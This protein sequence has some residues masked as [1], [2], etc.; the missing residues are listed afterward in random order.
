MDIGI[1]DEVV[2]PR[3]E[4]SEYVKTLEQ[5]ISR[6]EKLVKSRDDTLNELYELEKSKSDEINS[7]KE[8]IKQDGVETSKLQNIIKALNDEISSLNEKISDLEQQ[9]INNLKQQQIIEAS[10]PR[11]VENLLTDKESLYK[12]IA[13]LRLQ[14]SQLESNLQDKEEEYIALQTRFSEFEI[15]KEKEIQLLL[16]ES[17]DTKNFFSEKEQAQKDIYDSKIN[18]LDSDIN[19]LKSDCLDLLKLVALLQIKFT[20]NQEENFESIQNAINLI[21]RSLSLSDK[22]KELIKNDLNYDFN[23]SQ[24]IIS[25]SQVLIDSAI[26]LPNS[27]TNIEEIKVK[28]NDQTINLIQNWVITHFSSLL[29]NQLPLSP[30]NHTDSL[31]KERDYILNCIETEYFVVEK[32]LNKIFIDSEKSIEE[33]SPNVFQILSDILFLDINNS[34]IQSVEDGF[35]NSELTIIDRECREYLKTELLFKLVVK[36]VIKNDPEPLITNLNEI[37]SSINSELSKPQK[38]EFE[39]PEACIKIFS[40][41]KFIDS[42]LKLSFGYGWNFLHIFSYLEHIETLQLLLEHFS[43]EEQINIVNR[44]S[45]SGFIPISLS[46]LKNNLLMTELFLACGTD[47]QAQDNRRN[48]LIHFAVNSDIQ[49]VLIKRRILLN[50]KNSSGQIANVIQARPQIL[51]FDLNRFDNNESSD[52]EYKGSQPHKSNTSSINNYESDSGTSKK[53]SFCCQTF[54]SREVEN[55]VML[56]AWISGN[57]PISSCR[58]DFCV[59]STPEF[60]SRDSDVVESSVWNMLGFVGNRN[61][62]SIYKCKNGDHAAMEQNLDRLDEM[63]LTSAERKKGIWSDIVINYT[64]RG[65]EKSC[66]P[67]PLD[68]PINLFRQILVLTSERFAL[69][70]YSPL[71]LLQAAPIV[72]FEEIIVPKNSNVLLLI[73]VDGWDDIL[74]EVNRRSE[75]LDEFTTSYRTLTTPSEILLSQATAETSINSSTE[76]K[77]EKSSSFWL[78]FMGK[79]NLSSSTSNQKQDVLSPERFS[80]FQN[81]ISVYGENPPIVTEPDNLIGLFNSENQ[82]SLVL[83][84]I[85]KSSFMLLPHREASLLVSIPTYHFGF[86]G[87]CINPPLALE[88]PLSQKKKQFSESIA[89]SENELSENRLWQERFFI[90]RSDGALIWCHHPNDTVCCETIPIRFIR[91]IR[92]FNLATSK[93]SEFIPCFALDFTKNSVPSSLILHSDSSEMRD[94]WVEK[95][96]N[97]NHLRTSFLLKHISNKSA[98][99]NGPL[100]GKKILDVGSGAGIFSEKLAELGGDVL[101]IDASYKSIDIAYKNALCNSSNFSEIPKLYYENELNGF[102]IGV[103]KH[104]RL[105]YFKGG[106]EHMQQGELFDV[107]VASEVIEHVNNPSIFVQLISSNI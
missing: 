7:L 43:F 1:E 103:P 11:I 83:A 47:V 77:P 88:N 60:E 91:Q 13:D 35:Q 51:K 19:L 65:L 92:V 78:G 32:F 102:M 41:K 89:S 76:T 17:K 79:K 6:L 44:K 37:I 71:K 66:F 95:I 5:K 24:K 45:L 93:E 73:K 87:I 61:V 33:S 56:S 48:T 42:L 99:L 96:H 4:N 18:L 94:K 10:S 98:S 8:R 104:R 69:F 59:F 14:I 25:F 101:G 30:V 2:L 63:G 22:L 38:I 57:E 53:L 49:E 90:L 75:F 28:I 21:I 39:D 34:K 97:F 46:I 84:I 29:F 81:L 20:K 70:Q 107:I 58:D 50:A 31:Y 64:A 27:S 100:S 85:N 80:A 9:S 12:E 36:S 23:P 106:I 15:E 68:C 40:I 67:P 54:D 82:Y 86:L 26:N 55:K 72:D 3:S 62:S 74:L 52:A 105:G 16:S